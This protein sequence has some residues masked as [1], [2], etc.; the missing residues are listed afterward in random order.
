MMWLSTLRP[1]ERRTLAAVAN[2]GANAIDAVVRELRGRHPD[3][4]H[5]PASL[6]TRRFVDQPVC[7]VP[8]QGYVRPVPPGLREN[9]S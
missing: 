6:K 1:D 7:D 2:L 8:Y 5:T 9:Q 3:A 4:F